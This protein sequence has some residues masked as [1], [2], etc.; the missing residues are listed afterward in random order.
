MNTCPFKHATTTIVPTIKSYRTALLGLPSRKTSYKTLGTF[1]D[2]RSIIDT[3]QQHSPISSYISF[4]KV[5]KHG[6]YF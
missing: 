2:V 3:I 5:R 4:G 6:N 1:D